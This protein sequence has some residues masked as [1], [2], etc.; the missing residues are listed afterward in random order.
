[1]QVYDLE[2][3]YLHDSSHSGNVLK[4]FD[5]FLASGKGASK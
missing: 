5:G 2:T 4:G 1:M 3:T